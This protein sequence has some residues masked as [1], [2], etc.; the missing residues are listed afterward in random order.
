MSQQISEAKPSKRQ[1][2]G[3]RI[4]EVRKERGFTCEGL[5]MQ[6]GT[7]G[8]YIRQ[9]ESVRSP[10]LPGIDI[11][12]RICEVLDVTPNY[13]LQDQLK[14]GSQD[15]HADYVAMWENLPPSKQ[16]LIN[17]MIKTMA[18]QET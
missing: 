15:E 18:E 17:V 6:A 8:G 9:I 2:I 1:M 7:T 3:V 12:I 4:R 14:A 13:L 10:K 5:A 16:E 11:F